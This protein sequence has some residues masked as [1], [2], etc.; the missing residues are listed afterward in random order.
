MAGP[1]A[2]VASFTDEAS[3]DLAIAGKTEVTQMAKNDLLGLLTRV[4]R[5]Q[6]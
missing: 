1:N 4:L 5:S 6:R 2:P 3:R